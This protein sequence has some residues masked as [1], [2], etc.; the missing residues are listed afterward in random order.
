M[1]PTC[2]QIRKVVPHLTYN[3]IMNYKCTLRYGKVSNF[4]G[5]TICNVWDKVSFNSAFKSFS[6]FFIN[7][8]LYSYSS[9]LYFLA[10]YFLFFEPHPDPRAYHLMKIRHFFYVQ[11]HFLFSDDGIKFLNSYLHD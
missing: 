9:I 4:Y 8:D 10:T 3:C 7:F 2:K 1:T 6:S 5:N 11:L